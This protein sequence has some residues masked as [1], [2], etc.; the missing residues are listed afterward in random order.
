MRLQNSEDQ[1]L[2]YILLLK[3]N[4]TQI[5]PRTKVWEILFSELKETDL[6]GN[7][8][9]EIMQVRTAKATLEKYR[10]DY[11]NVYRYTVKKKVTYESTGIEVLFNGLLHEEKLFKKDF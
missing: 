11:K 7:T 8:Q 10:D 3:M 9:G 6:V 5:V 1:E 2:F 4:T